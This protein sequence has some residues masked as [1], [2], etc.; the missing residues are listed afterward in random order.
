[1]HK[2]VF[3][4][5]NVNHH[6]EICSFEAEEPKDAI[7]KIMNN[8]YWENKKSSHFIYKGHLFKVW[9]FGNFFVRLET[10]DEFFVRN[11]KG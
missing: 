8:L 10:L 5:R 1:M 7:K 11:S 9:D 4:Y 2:Y 6:V 3:T